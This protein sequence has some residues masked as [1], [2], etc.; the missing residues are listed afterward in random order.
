M[1]SKVEMF[2]PHTKRW[3]ELGRARPGDMDIMRE[4]LTAVHPRSVLTAR[5]SEDNITTTVHRVKLKP[6][7]VLFER[8]TIDPE[9]IESEELLATLTSGDKPLERRILWKDGKMLSIRYSH[10]PRR[11]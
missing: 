10:I 8:N 7:T 5:C 4:D 3:S 2:S 1:V 11:R 6:G 9:T